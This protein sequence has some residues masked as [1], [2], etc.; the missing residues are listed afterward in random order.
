MHFK[1]LQV[2]NGVI[3]KSLEN[4][5]SFVVNGLKS[6]EWL[7]SS[8]NTCTGLLDLSIEIVTNTGL[9]IRMAELSELVSDS[10]EIGK[11]V[12]GSGIFLNAVNPWLLELSETI[13]SLN[14]WVQ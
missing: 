6:I 2:F 5:V 14:L 12:S 1:A 4:S 7:A 13:K 10:A 9:M 11:L 8:F 3:S